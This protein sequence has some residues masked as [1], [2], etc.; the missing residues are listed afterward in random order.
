[1][2]IPENKNKIPL[3]NKGCREESIRDLK[4]IADASYCMWTVVQKSE[5][6]VGNWKV[7]RG[8]IIHLGTKL[9]AKDN[10]KPDVCVHL[11][12]KY[13][14]SCEGHLCNYALPMCSWIR[15]ENPEDKRPLG[16]FEDNPKRSGT[17]IKK[18][19]NN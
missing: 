9:L 3:N 14:C 5:T 19:L 18:Y 6:W 4:S 8:S 12:G 2:S 1:M 7:N 17:S 10:P 15:K 11:E 13:H 16:C